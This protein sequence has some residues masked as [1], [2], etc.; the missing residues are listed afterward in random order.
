MNLESLRKLIKEEVEGALDEAD[1]ASQGPPKT[2]ADF[3]KRMGVALKKAGA[4]PA[5]VGEVNDTGYEGGGVFSALW[6]AWEG[7]EMELKD[8]GD[9][10]SEVWKDMVEYYVHDAVIDMM[11]EY[12]NPMNYEPGHKTGKLDSPAL[13]KATVAAMLG[14]Q[15]AK[16]KPA[17]E[18][19]KAMIPALKQ[20]VKLVASVVGGVAKVRSIS[21]NL[22]SKYSPYQTIR[23]NGDPAAVAEA[24]TGLEAQGW[25][26]TEFEGETWLESGEGIAKVGLDLSDPLNGKSWVTVTTIPED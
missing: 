19:G 23:F 3:R 15:V 12:G 7:I 17:P 2:F 4:D 6:R 1:K 21:G 10:A 24:L 14:N 25:T 5:L 18:G 16:V 9:E 13:A 8:A 26:R 20:A 22:K 11:D